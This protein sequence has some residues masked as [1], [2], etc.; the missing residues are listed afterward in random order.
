MADKDSEKKQW[1]DPKDYGL[2]FVEITPI[3]VRAKPVVE[4][5]TKV[6]SDPEVQQEATVPLAVE[7]TSQPVSEEKNKERKPEKQVQT[8]PVNRPI[9]P[10][11]STSWVWAAVLI[12]LGIVSVIIWQIQSQLDSSSPENS[13]EKTEKPIVENQPIT[14]QESPES[15][16]SEQNQP[17]VNQ[18]SIISI[19]NSNPNISKPAETGTTIANRVTGNLI[20]IESKAERPQYFIIVGSLPSEKLAIEEATVYFG[21]TSD[22]YLIMPYEGV[23]NYRLAIGKFGSFKTAAEEL[24]KIKSQYSEALWILKY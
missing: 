17:A 18:D 3:R 4:E 13:V 24:E 7:P 2:P 5:V 10:K 22:I 21:R 16:P 8:P 19:N 15:T 11:K 14:T 20:R 23:S 9:E 6:I 12:G 1:T